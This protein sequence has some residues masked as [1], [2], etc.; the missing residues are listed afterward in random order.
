MSEFADLFS[1][2]VTDKH[3][4]ISKKLSE[5][6]Q[7]SFSTHVEQ[8]LSSLF[9]ESGRVNEPEL[10]E[11]WSVVAADAGRNQIEFKN[12][13]RMFMIQAAAVD[14]N[15]SKS[16][17]LLT[18][19]VTPFKSK[20]YG[21]FVGRCGELV[22]I[23][24]ILTSLKDREHS[25]ETFV[26]IDGSLLTRMLVVPKEFKMSDYQ[27][28]KIDLINRF[29]EL[30]KLSREEPNLHIIGVSKDSNT[31]ILYKEV[32]KRAAE[33]AC[34][35]A[36]ADQDIQEKVMEIIDAV[37][38]DTK[39]AK[40]RMEQLQSKT[41]TD[42]S[43]PADIVDNFSRKYSDI[44][45]IE[46]IISEPG[47]T[48]PVVSAR[49]SRRFKRRLNKIRDDADEYVESRY[50][51]FL[52]DSED[53]DRQKSR[54]KSSLNKLKDYP[55]VATAYWTP[56]KEAQPIRLDLL[57]DEWNN[58]D[59]MGSLTETKFLKHNNVFEK[60]LSV[61]E[62]GYAGETMH[63]IWISQADNA[64]SLSKSDVK[65]IYAPILSDELGINMKQYLRRRD[66]RD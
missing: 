12:N 54:I 49:S 42:L 5:A 10:G 23:Q 1:K 40:N 53:R 8:E 20:D 18:G 37:E 13:T 17:E 62:T 32:M 39:T 51:D 45:M 22:E 21:E 50:E 9:T 36:N 28:K 47:V 19:A 63:N 2:Q 4:A 34:E 11:K 30:L 38:S 7:H 26:L 66:K 55:A 52:R 16:K 25:E 57:T 35:Q 6:N 14:S 24:A 61:L 64:A 33:S 29:H 60:L 15:G 65:N 43:E 48:K 3:K 58:N 59:K 41:E 27:E 56:E 31:N 46:S 44:G